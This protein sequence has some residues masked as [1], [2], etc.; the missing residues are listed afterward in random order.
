VLPFKGNLNSRVCLMVDGCVQITRKT[1]DDTTSVEFV[2]YYGQGV[3]YAVVMRL[4]NGTSTLPRGTAAGVVAYVPAVTYSCN[5]IDDQCAKDGEFV[6]QSESDVYNE[7]SAAVIS[8]CDVV[9]M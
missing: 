1:H 9:I 2:A 8:H 7:A 6:S 5:F 3:V 4:S